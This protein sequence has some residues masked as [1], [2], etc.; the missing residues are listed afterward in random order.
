MRDGLRQAGGTVGQV[1]LPIKPGTSCWTGQI[2]EAQVL[3]LAVSELA[4]GPGAV[5]LLLPRLLL[6]EALEPDL[7]AGLAVGGLVPSL[8]RH[9]LLTEEKPRSPGA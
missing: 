4:E 5:D 9:R 1:G 7:I 2:G 8:P 6:G 3:G